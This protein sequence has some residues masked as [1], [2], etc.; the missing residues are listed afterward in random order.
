MRAILSDIHGNLEALQAVLADIEAHDVQDIY[1]LGD[2][3]GYG[4]NPLECLAESTAWKVILLGNFDQAAIA[5]EPLTGWGVYAGRSLDWAR[6]LL[7]SQRDPNQLGAFLTH[8]P[9]SH[10]EQDILFV[11]GTPCNP[12][13]EYLIPEDIYNPTKMARIWEHFDRLS[14]T[15][16]THLPGVFVEESPALWDFHCPEE[17]GSIYPFDGRR[18]ICNVGSVGQPHDGD[19]RA[20][21]VLFDGQ[22]VRFRRVEYDVNATVRKIHANPELEDFLGDRLLEGR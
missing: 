15:G 19:W 21:Y 12:L 8:L 13:Q 9:L 20:C 17:C 1:C 18:A 7:D 16:H 22:T 6:T 14:F 11:H 10:Q 3:V 2:T 5:P 4:P